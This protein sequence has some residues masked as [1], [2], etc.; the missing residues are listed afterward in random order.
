[1]LKT[2]SKCGA[3]KDAET[4]FW[5]VKHRSGNMAS[6]AECIVCSKERS[7]KYRKTL[8]GK[9]AIKKAKIKYEAQPSIVIKRKKRNQSRRQTEQWKTK[10]KVHQKKYRMTD[11]GRLKARENCKTYNSTE[12]G[13]KKRKEHSRSIIHQYSILKSS[14][15]RRSIPVEM[16]IEELASLIDKSKVCYY[17]GYSIENIRRLMIFARSYEGLNELC[18][19]IKNRIKINAFDANKLSPDRSN[20]LTSYKIDN[21]VMACPICNQA[22]GWI[23]PGDVYMRIAV[24][25]IANIVKICEDAGLV[26]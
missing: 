10:Q 14:A 22:K 24:D 25:T 6:R 2:C 1:M 12:N 9:E 16:S 19:G 20:S 17:C 4:E 23:I 7:G 18:I 5:I 15:R 8:A 13:R 3:E 21:C 11:A 26:I